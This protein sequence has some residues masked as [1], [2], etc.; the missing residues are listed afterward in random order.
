MVEL[1]S[2]RRLLVGISL[3]LYAL[4]FDALLLS[5]RTDLGIGRFFYLAIAVLAL[6][7]GPLAGAAAGLL[8]AALYA[9]AVIHSSDD[10]SLRALEL[11][12]R[13]SL[14]DL[15]PARRARGRDRAEQ[16]RAARQAPRPRRVRCADRPR[17]L[18]Q[19]RERDRG[20]V[21]GRQ[22]LRA[23]DRRHGLPQADQRRLRP[24]GGRR[25]AEAARGGALTVAGRAGR[26]L[27]D[28]RRRVRR[29]GRG[30]HRRSAR[31]A[32]P[33]ASRPSSPRRARASASAGPSPRRTATAR[34]RSTGPR[35][36]ACTRASAPAGSTE[37]GSA[38]CRTGPPRSSRPRAGRPRTTACG[39]RSRSRGPT[40]SRRA[41]DRP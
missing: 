7:T 9:I 34:S 19:L 22:A 1:L 32:S 39:R 25:D 29:P 21:R 15:R 17:Q 18:A 31:D 6:A 41:P 2:R 12:E 35:T 33:P 5:Q 13:L 27:P 14:R 36:R 24:R 37:P 16:P 23:P 3:V 40:A 28:R 10:G 11:G 4:V 38:A 26:R 8:A 30:G 20:A